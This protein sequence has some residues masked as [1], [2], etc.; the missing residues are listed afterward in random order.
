MDRP[1]GITGLCQCGHPHGSA[2]Q[3][4]T[5]GPRLKDKQEREGA[6]TPAM[7]HRRQPA[8]DCAVRQALGTFLPGD[9]FAR[10]GRGGGGL[11]PRQRS[12]SIHSGLSGL[13]GRP[14]RGSETEQS[15]RLSSSSLLGAKVGVC[16]ELP[17]RPLCAGTRP[18]PPADS[19]P[20]ACSPEEAGRT[21]PPQSGRAWGWRPGF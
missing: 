1:A 12:H 9:L 2:G 19:P 18:E 8:W 17:E 6:A 14:G 10:R 16:E 21:H 7:V 11:S 13:S 5:E 3:W 4:G 15:S 20:I